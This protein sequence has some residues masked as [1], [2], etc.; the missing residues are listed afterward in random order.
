M[1]MDNV[2]LQSE[3]EETVPRDNR[4]SRNQIKTRSS[5]FQSI[6]KHWRDY[7]STVLNQKLNNV[8]DDLVRNMSTADYQEIRRNN[9]LVSKLEEKIEILSKSDVPSKYIKH[10]AI[11][12]REKMMNSV[13]LN[14]AKA[15]A[16]KVFASKTNLV[17]SSPIEKVASDFV[18]PPVVESMAAANT[19]SPIINV[20]SVSNEQ[21]KVLADEIDRAMGEAYY[22]AQP[23]VDEP[24]NRNDIEQ[25]VEDAF[26]VDNS[27]FQP[28]ENEP[29]SRNEIEQVVEN[30]FTVDNNTIQSVESEPVSRSDIEQVVENSFN[31]VEDNVKV[32]T[33]EEVA[34]VVNEN[35]D[36]GYETVEA[37]DLKA[38]ESVGEVNNAE[39]VIDYSHLKEA[40]DQA[41]ADIQFSQN[42][43]SAVSVDLLPPSV[44]EPFEYKPMTD[45]EI[46]EARENIEYEKYEDIY[47]KEWAAKQE[48][49]QNDAEVV[50]GGFEPIHD[51][52]SSTSEV[53]REDIVVVPDR[54]ETVE[55]VVE[56][57]ADNDLHF[58]YSEATESDL[59]EASKVEKSMMGLSE[60]KERALKLKEQNRQS[61]IEL[62]AAKSAQ[63]EEARKALEIRNAN[64]SKKL[65]YVE[66]L[67]K[68]Q[69][70]CDSLEEDTQSTYNSVENARIETESNRQF[71]QS[72][73][74]EISDYDSKMKEID[75]II[76]GD[77]ILK[78]R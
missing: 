52:I 20:E 66:A 56:K 17:S 46:A 59:V 65:D 31:N 41:L 77:D 24:I 43:T 61:K 8:K 28:V 32:V 22:D 57:P 78:R 37:G 75:S 40:V 51:V 39:P 7:R 48:A 16:E 27:A 34:E 26:A 71:I 55:K 64:L 19:S 2:Q 74:D 12:L 69:E 72:Q 63:I 54:E 25:V 62:D 35:H 18:V 70:F 4:V 11:K 6:Y 21:E 36:S 29:I 44:E 1:N 67:R 13:Y 23:V 14:S 60:L 38:V 45:E 47:A 5:S 30:A 15:Y 53:P 58:D 3:I 9:N 42:D 49:K 33:P 76:S 68:L 10:R 50:F 73:Y